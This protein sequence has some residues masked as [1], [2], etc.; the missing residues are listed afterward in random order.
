MSKEFDF[1]K[2]EWQLL[3][4]LEI[5]EKCVNLKPGQKLEYSFKS[6]AELSFNIHFHR[7][8]SPVY[9]QNEK[10][11]VFKKGILV[12]PKKSQFCLMW[13]NPSMEDIR[14]SYDTQLLSELENQ[15]KNR[16]PVHFKVATDK[17]AVRIVA[18]TGLELSRLEIGS[19]ILN[20]ELNNNAT[21]LAVSVA[22]LKETLLIYDAKTLQII[23]KVTLKRFPTLL[24][25][26][27][28]SRFL[29]VGD[30]HSENIIRIDLKNSRQQTLA[31]PLSPLA[32]MSGEEPGEL[33]VRVE[34]EV[35]KIQI[36]PLQL[37]ERNAR[38]E[39]N[40]GEESFFA[41]P[42]DICTAHG[43]PH[44]LFTPKEVAMSQ[45]GLQGYY[46]QEK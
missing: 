17:Q 10:D 14:L 18:D 38:I 34:R 42:D 1:E 7:Q 43:I 20:F 35:L 25:F 36:D 46:F 28:D 2:M 8:G 40:F 11:I 41:D 3:K 33:L 4:G 15:E 29:I 22:D 5:E 44:P 9:L 27:T 26:S 23:T 13:V 16:I 37:L 45:E 19:N 30:E 24:V 31:L 12:P 6:S 21:M 39:F 32:L